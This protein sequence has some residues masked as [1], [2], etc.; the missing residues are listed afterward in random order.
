MGKPRRRVRIQMKPGMGPEA[1]EGVEIGRRRR[2]D[3]HYVVWAAKVLV[4]END[5]YTVEGALEVPVE[6]TILR[7]V[8]V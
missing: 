6:N 8:L 1:I 7:Q 2:V 4:N 3:G 5:S